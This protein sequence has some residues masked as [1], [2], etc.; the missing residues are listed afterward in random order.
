[1]PGMDVLLEG[2][3]LNR[4]S[5]ILPSKNVE[6]QA[7]YRWDAIIILVGNNLDQFGRAIATPPR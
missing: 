1:M 6:A 3:D 4:D 2:S 5:G 7:C